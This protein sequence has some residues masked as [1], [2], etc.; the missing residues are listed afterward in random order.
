MLG[1]ALLFAGRE[2]TVAAIDK[3]VVLLLANPGFGETLGRDPS[4]VDPSVEEILR[5]PLPVGWPEETGATGLPRWAKAD[6]DIDGTTIP[7]GELVLLDLQGA[8]LDGRVFPS[9]ETLDPDRAHNP[10]LAFGHGAYFCLG[11]PLA[12]MELRVLFASLFRHFPRLRLA[13]PVAELR[14]RNRVLTGGLHELPVAW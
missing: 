14:P 12:R 10:H 8:N 6:I 1:A 13:V 9:P 11:A 5:L 2:T 4:L 7:A 3:G